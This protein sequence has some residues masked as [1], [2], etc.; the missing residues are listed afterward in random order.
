MTAKCVDAP[1]VS[2]QFISAVPAHLKQ[3]VAPKAIKW[4]KQ[5][6]NRKGPRWSSSDL[7]SRP[8]LRTAT[9][10]VCKILYNISN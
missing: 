2:V 9:T 4:M 6:G 7:P 5:P 8:A 1:S 10:S 3:A